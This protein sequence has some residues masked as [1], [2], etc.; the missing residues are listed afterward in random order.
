[1]RETRVVMGMPITVEIVDCP[2]AGVVGGVFAYFEAIDRRF[3]VFRPD[4][5][6]MAFNRRRLARTEISASLREVLALADQTRRRTNGYFDVCRPDGLID[7]S[8]IVKGW[9]IRNASR[10]ID[11]AGAK[12]YVID[13]GGD[14]QSRG[15]AADGTDWKIGIRHPFNDQ[16][17]VKVVHPLGH[18]VATS[19][20]YA[21]GEHIYNP[22][23]PDQ[24]IV[25]IVS[26]TVIGSDVLQ[27]DLYATAA[28]AMGNEGIYF[29]E[30]MPQLEGYAIGMNGVATQ[31]TG[32]AK[33]VVS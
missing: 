31:T 16:A 11:A 24:P 9:A 1:M 7:P 30:K 6:I 28:F 27:A 13:A 21:R 22:R 5:E 15:K 25:D 14:I 26:L 3:S 8:G 2:S 10:L 32:F 33:F 20:I 19:G 29:V 23:R 12:H 18:G 4:S 17:I